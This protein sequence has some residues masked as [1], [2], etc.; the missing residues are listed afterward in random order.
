MKK[1]PIDKRFS[2]RITYIRNRKGMTQVPEGFRAT[3]RIDT[4]KQYE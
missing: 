1:K 4:L 2:E 3:K